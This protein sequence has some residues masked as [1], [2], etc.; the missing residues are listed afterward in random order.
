[1]NSE[2]ERQGSRPTWTPSP[3][4]CADCGTTDQVA[5]YKYARWADTPQG[6]A[7]LSCAVGLCPP[8][9]RKRALAEKQG[10]LKGTPWMGTRKE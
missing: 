9:A 6:K 7:L 1:V 8:C 5:V 2:T 10:G 4:P 3:D